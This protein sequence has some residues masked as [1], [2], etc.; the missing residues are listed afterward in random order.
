M[1]ASKQAAKDFIA[2]L[3]PSFNVALVGLSASSSVLAPPTTD[4]GMLNRVIE[5]M[6]VQDGTTGDA[7][8][9]AISA[10]GMAPVNRAPTR[11]P[12]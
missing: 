8:M 1:D 2:E 5:Q 11:P 3:P 4:R 9:A 7:I 6:G 10:V 12:P